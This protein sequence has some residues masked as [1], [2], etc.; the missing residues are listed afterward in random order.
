M[1]NIYFISGPCGVGKSTLADAYAKHLTNSGLRKQAFVIHGDDFHQG[2]VETDDK[3]S[4]WQDGQAKDRIGWLEILKFN[5]ECIID[6]AGRVLSRDLD[7]VIDYV[8]EE[9]LPLLLKLAK[10]H[11]AKLYYI[12]LT[13]SEETITRRIKERGDEEMVERALFLKNKLENLPENQGHILDNTGRSISEEIDEIE[14]NKEDYRCEVTRAN[15]ETQDLAFTTNVDSS[16]AET[17]NSSVAEEEVGNS[18]KDR[19][20]TEP[21]SSN[22]QMGQVVYYRDDRLTIRSMVP[23]DAKIYFDTYTSYDWHPQIE[24][25]ENYYKEQEN[26]ERFVFVPEIEGKVVGICTLVLHPSEGPWGGQNIPE[27]VDLCVFFHIHKAGI[28]SK[29]LDV[30]EAEAAKCSDTVFLAVG[31]HS[32][33]GA[34]QR[35]YVKRGYIPD[36]SGVWYQNKQLDQYAPC[37]NDDDLLLFLSKKLK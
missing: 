25:Y 23:E 7:V 17:L 5:W 14:K 18:E 27:I 4:F 12:V 26:G 36:G 19:G 28:G 2:F 15:S 6:T 24:T 33:Y 8:V 22:G 34:A 31:C 16:A 35:I 20:G 37:V 3:D 29:L 11:D 9:E 32:G 10:E 13:A 21:F 30:A 1:G